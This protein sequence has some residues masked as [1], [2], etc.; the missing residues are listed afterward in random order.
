[1][2]QKLDADNVTLEEE[3]RKERFNAHKYA[4]ISAFLSQVSLLFEGH[5]ENKALSVRPTSFVTHTR[6]TDTTQRRERQEG[7]GGGKLVMRGCR[8]AAAGRLIMRN[9]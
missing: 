7:E 6:H 5:K 8:R 4:R 9:G 1:M 3:K 2:E